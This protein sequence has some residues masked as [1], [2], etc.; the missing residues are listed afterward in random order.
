MNGGDC[1]SRMSVGEMWL[2]L[3]VLVVYAF[4]PSILMG[5]CKWVCYMERKLQGERDD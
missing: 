4:Y 3:L 2:G 5:L 1:I